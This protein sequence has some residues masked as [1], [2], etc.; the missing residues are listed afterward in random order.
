MGSRYFKMPGT[1]FEG[2]QRSFYSLDL[3]LH[4]EVL[5]KPSAILFAIFSGLTLP[6]RNTFRFQHTR[7]ITLA[8][9]LNSHH[10]GHLSKLCSYYLFRNGENHFEINACL[11]GPFFK[12]SLLI[13]KTKQ[14]KT[15]QKQK[16]NYSKACGNCS[17]CI[18]L[19][20]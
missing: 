1:N 6:C 8:S 11:K 12:N 2:E 14:N 7:L 17:N 19:E 10:V 4:S 3:S 5:N 18:L 15:K 13:E 20:R 16:T 9:T